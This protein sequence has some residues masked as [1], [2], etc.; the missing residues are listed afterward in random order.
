MKK[1]LVFLVLCFN[2]MGLFAMDINKVKKEIEDYL[3]SQKG[4]FSVAFMEL[5]NKQNIILINE[6][7]VFHTASTMKTPVMAE[8]FHQIDSGILSL[9]DTILVKNDFTSIVDGSHFSIDLKSDSGLRINKLIGEYTTIYNLIEDMITNSSNLATNILIEKVSAQNVNNLMRS[10]GAQNIN[11]LRGVE[12]TK[13]FENGMSNTTTSLDMLK[14]YEAIYFN[15]IAKK[16]SCDIMIDILKKQNHNN[17]IPKYLPKSVKV[18]HKTGT[19]EKVVHDCGI[20]YPENGKNYILIY[21]SKEVESN[22]IS[23]EIGAKL[24]EMI[25]K[26]IMEK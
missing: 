5:E 23:K 2:Y 16:E 1:I 6:N 25:Y 11:I 18:A 20:V 8:I 17:V 4:V 12:D 22:D 26:S 21:L 13:A 3:S 15:K 19:I 10:I 14:I 9:N 24:S 7:E